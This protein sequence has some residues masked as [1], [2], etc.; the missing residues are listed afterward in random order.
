M[1]TRPSS[2]FEPSVQPNK[3]S[4]EIQL[5]AQLWLLTAATCRRS[6]RFDQAI[7]AIQ[8]AELL[9]NTNPEVWVQVRSSLL[10]SFS[11]FLSF[12]SDIEN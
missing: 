5:L 4:P 12:F 7:S 6:G 1:P 11:F 2:P 8:E 9:D 10:F 3:V